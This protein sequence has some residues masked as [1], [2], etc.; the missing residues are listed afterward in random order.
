MRAARP[1][2]ELQ[3]RS[4]RRTGR[5][6]PL[7]AGSTS[8]ARGIA[9]VVQRRVKKHAR[10]PLT[11]AAYFVGRSRSWTAGSSPASV[12]EARPECWNTDTVN[13]VDF[14]R[15][16]RVTVRLDVELHHASRRPKQAQRIAF[17]RGRRYRA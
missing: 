17:L 9:G 10:M 1:A 5:L 4:H 2:E 16:V 11:S 7:R 6:Q 8:L 3:T 12:P 14:G 15:D 13:V